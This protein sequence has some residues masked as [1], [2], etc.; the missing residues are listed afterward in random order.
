MGFDNSDSTRVEL[1]M[2]YKPENP[3]ALIAIPILAA[4]NAFAL[5]VLLPRAIKRA[6]RPPVPLDQF[7]NLMGWA[8]GG[9]GIAHAADCYGGSSQLLITAGS[10]P[11][12]DLGAC[13]RGLRGGRGGSAPRR[14]PPHHPQDPPLRTWWPCGE[15]QRRPGR[16]S[17]RL[18]V[19]PSRAPS[20]LQHRPSVR[21]SRC[22][23]GPVAW[24]AAQV[25]GRVADAGLVAYGMIEVSPGFVRTCPKL[26]PCVSLPPS[27]TPPATVR[28]SC[29]PPPPA[30]PTHHH[31]VT[32]AALISALAP[33]AG[34]GAVVN[35]LVVQAVV[36][37]SWVYS[38]QKQEEPPQ[39]SVAEL[40]S[41]GSGG[42]SGSG[43]GGGDDGGDGDDENGGTALDKINAFLDR[44]LL[45]V[46][47][48]CLW[49]SRP[50]AP[51]GHDMTI[52]PVPT[53]QCA[54]RAARAT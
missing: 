4:D 47:W 37:A 34:I 14:K 33:N 31:Q 23:S 42:T 11:F 21:P 32:G 28:A 30:H 26:L 48:W 44:P 38:S 1:L 50:L 54:R 3:I 27:F 41:S 9:A 35:A 43:G 8:Y 18:S 5:K 25:G 53:D 29:P 7:R 46:S 52:T 16:S 13:V 17:R 40:S 2:S 24:A 49:Y 36:G 6:G 19:R 15:C 45:D 12:T 22:I 20:V 39:P 51:H 10:P